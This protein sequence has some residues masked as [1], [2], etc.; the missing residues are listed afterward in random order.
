MQVEDVMRNSDRGPGPFQ[1]STAPRAELLPTWAA[2]LQWWWRCRLSKWFIRCVNPLSSNMSVA[3]GLCR[4][5]P[6]RGIMLRICME[7]T[8]NLQCAGTQDA[9][10]C[11]TSLRSAML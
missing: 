7:S 1:S 6:S 11:T 5:W 2:T 9:L 3:T 4:L 8:I 10:M